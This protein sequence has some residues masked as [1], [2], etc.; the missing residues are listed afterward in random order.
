M[1]RPNRPSFILRHKLQ[2]VPIAALVCSCGLAQTNSETPTDVLREV[3]LQSDLSDPRGLSVRSND[4]RLQAIQRLGQIRS[5][6]AVAVLKAYLTT[7]GASRKLKQRALVA[8]GKIGSEDAVGAVESFE[9][10]AERS[11][12]D[13]P[14]FRF[15]KRDWGIDHY[16]QHDL[17]PLVRAKDPQG[18]EVV[19]F[20]WMRF[21]SAQ[22]RLWITTATENDTWSSP[23]LID[24]PDLPRIKTETSVG[25][26]V[27]QDAVTLIIDK[28][29]FKASLT[30]LSRDGDEDGLL[31]SVERVLGT[32]PS[33]PDT[34]EDGIDDGKDGN[35]LTPRSNK[36]DDASEIRQA[37]FTVLFATCNS[38]DSIVIV[39]EGNAA[40]QEYYGYSGT[41]IKAAKPNFG[42]SIRDIT[43]KLESQD[44]AT[45][46]VRESL[47][48]YKA[49]LR[50][51]HGKWVIVEFMMTWI[52]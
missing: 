7:Y 8:L 19:V 15:G 21:G 4:P 50:R 26:S 20:R 5:R 23:L 43:V 2:L 25:L 9:A 3:L 11:R 14:P 10:W 28:Q 24:L 12:L 35:P 46:T 42:V 45:V 16:A 1:Q 44:E 33:R 51:M 27:G 22:P 40:Q 34:D 37:V 17:K 41:V 13:P 31:D 29:T 52:S 36:T 47:A 30:Q 38:A 6:E 39:D 48:G 18:K 32:D 49:K